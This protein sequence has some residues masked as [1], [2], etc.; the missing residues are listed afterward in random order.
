MTR[1]M[2]TLGLGGLAVMFDPQAFDW[3]N[4]RALVG[5]ALVLLAALCWA[6]CILYVGA[7]R[8]VSTPFQVVFWQVLLASGIISALALHVDGLPQIL[9]TPK[10]AT[11]FGYGGV[12]GA[13]LALD[14]GYGQPQ[15]VHR[16]DVA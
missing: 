3:T 1:Q 8:W 6:A 4:D 14:D 11:T 7:L 5:N 10:F 2:A 9:W 16:D 13:A 15:P 12:F